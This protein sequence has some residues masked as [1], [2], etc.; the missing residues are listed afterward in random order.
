MKSGKKDNTEPVTRALARAANYEITIAEKAR[1]SARRAWWVAAAAVAMS[2]FLAGGYLLVMPLKEKVPYLVMADAY[3]GQA[4]VARL[5]EDSITGSEALNR[6]NVATFIRSRESYDWTLVGARDWSTVFVMAEPEVAFEYRGLYSERNTRGPLVQYGKKFAIR[7]KI[8]SIQTFAGDADRKSSGATVRFQ[9]TLLDKSTGQSRL[10]DNRIATMEYV[11]KPN[12]EMSDE[13][14]ML[15]PL[16]FRVTT[17]RVDNDYSATPAVA[18]DAPRATAPEV[19]PH[20]GLDA[21]A[22]GTVAP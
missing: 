8:L 10:L 21:S 13:D 19:E 11:Y 7:V 2:L 17:Y 20:A 4:T 16:G 15:N 3:T 12:L 9:R 1:R 22:S 14:R 6:A 5:K 18:D